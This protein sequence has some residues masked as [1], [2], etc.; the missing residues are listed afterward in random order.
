M[1]RRQNAG[2]HVFELQVVSTLCCLVTL[3]WLTAENMPGLIML[4][5]IKEAECLHRITSLLCRIIASRKDR[6]KKIL[7]NRTFRPHGLPRHFAEE[8]REDEM[9]C[10]IKSF[11][12]P[13]FSGF[14]S[15]PFGGKLSP[16]YQCWSVSPVLNARPLPGLLPWWKMA[17]LGR[18]KPRPC[19]SETQGSNGGRRATFALSKELQRGGGKGTEGSFENSPSNQPKKSLRE[20]DGCLKKRWSCRADSGYVLSWRCPDCSRHRGRWFSWRY[21]LSLLHGRAPSTR[22]CSAFS[23]HGPTYL[24]KCLCP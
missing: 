6:R 24:L 2:L 17:A 22:F 4:H 19:S 9:S 10:S 16:F 18:Q 15:L 1:V 21:Q 14:T 7:L 5:L 23:V 20:I 12:S 3:V 8:A 13:V 11:F